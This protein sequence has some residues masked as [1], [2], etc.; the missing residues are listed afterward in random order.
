M[1]EFS[2]SEWVDTLEKCQLEKEEEGEKHT[3]A[4]EACTDGANNKGKENGVLAHTQGGRWRVRPADETTKE[5]EKEETE[6]LIVDEEE[7]EGRLKVLRESERD[8][9]NTG[10]LNEILQV[11]YDE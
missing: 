5:L 10:A 1:Q 6:V 3:T 2:K 9:V 4:A 11:P 8:M 7:E